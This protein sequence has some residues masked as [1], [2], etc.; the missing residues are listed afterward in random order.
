MKN[1]Q[2]QI[3]MKFKVVF[4]Y[5]DWKGTPEDHARLRQLEQKSIRDG[6]CTQQELD[7][8]HLICAAM[9]P[10]FVDNVIVPSLVSKFR[11]EKRDKPRK[12]PQK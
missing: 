2:S 3:S 10:A 8:W 12:Q 7:N 9:W 5:W 11:K 1:Q 6:Y 4:P